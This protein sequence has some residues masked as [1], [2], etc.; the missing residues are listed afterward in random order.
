M[1]W[2]EVEGVVEVADAGLAA[3]VARHQRQQAQPHRVGERLEQRRHLLGLVRGHRR[4]QQRVAAGPRRPPREV[5]TVVEDSETF[6]AETGPDG[7]C[8]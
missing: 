7:C 3:L 5:Y 1:G 8:G 4:A 6:F 2:D